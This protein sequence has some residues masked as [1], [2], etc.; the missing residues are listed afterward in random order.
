MPRKSEIMQMDLQREF[1]STMNLLRSIW[2]EIGMPD[3]QV[4]IH[5]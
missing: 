5:I 3:D 1:S 4:C 2:D